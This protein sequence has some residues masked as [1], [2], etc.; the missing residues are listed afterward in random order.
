[1]KDTPCFEFPVT[2]YNI[3]EQ[4]TPTLSKARVRI[5]YKGAN[6]NGSFITDEFAEKLISTLPYAPVKGIYDAGQGDYT[7]HGPDNNYGRIYGVVPVDNNFAWEKNADD[8]GVLRTYAT[9]DVYLYTA[10]YKEAGE[11][12][13]KSQSMEL[14][15]PSISGEWIVYQ[16][17]RY[18]K[19][20]DGAFFGLQV[21]GD[22]VEPCFEGASF[23]TVQNAE[24]GIKQLT[25]I[26]EQLNAYVLKYSYGG[27]SKMELNFK[28]SDREKFD[29]IWT[30]LNTRY[31][32]EGGWEITYCILDIYD[33]YALVFNYE[34]NR[35]ERVTYTKNDEA[36][37][38][39]LGEFSVR[40]V[41][42]LSENEK[43]LVDGLRT[44]A[45][46]FELLSEAYEAGQKAIEDLKA[47]DEEISEYSTKISE[48]ENN[49]ST[50][51]TE[52]ETTEN[53]FAELSDKFSVLEEEVNSLR[54]YKASSEKEKKLAV[55]KSY[56]SVL[57]EDAI[58][59]FTNRV[60]EYADVISLD[61][62]L[63]YALKNSNF[64][65]FTQTP[66]FIP[67]SDNGSQ[68]DLRELLTQYKK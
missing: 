55:I 6:R 38:V 27:K 11:I 7:D 37:T 2:I 20:T 48:L 24:E 35:Y 18:F 4:I 39:E 8:D 30:L 54:A 13:G 22:A 57:N 40:Y 43:A 64:S 50:L 52:K 45:G 3:L 62:D 65:I 33:E 44:A 68:G 58:E 10:M 15:P 47:R 21:L 34:Y 17:S 63:A 51:N 14:Y 19:F 31:N 5:F 41:M 28:V 32:E 12:V 29:A 60:D 23:F 9:C 61:K 56:E 66:E 36:D 49:I 42:D 26:I 1:M 46:S 25:K 67:M 59:D 53:N 16:G